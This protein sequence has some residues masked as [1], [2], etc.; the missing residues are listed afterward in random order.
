M[1]LIF[2]HSPSVTVKFSITAP[3]TVR[4][5]VPVRIVIVSISGVIYS[6]VISTEI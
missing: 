6:F 1:N 3:L 5:E 4:I 2:Y